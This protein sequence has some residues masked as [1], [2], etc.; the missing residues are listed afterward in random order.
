M[1]KMRSEC[2]LLQFMQGFRRT[3]LPRLPKPECN[4]LMRVLD[5]RVSPQVKQ[6][7]RLAL[8]RLTAVPRGLC[9]VSLSAQNLAIVLII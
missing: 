9:Y 3:D 8:S 4:L 6:K 2:D 1:R 7:L 5:L